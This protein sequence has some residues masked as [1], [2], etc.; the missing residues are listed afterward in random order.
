M[1]AIILLRWI[2]S[3]LFFDDAS[4]DCRRLSA[5][6]KPPVHEKSWSPPRNAATA[7]SASTF[8]LYLSGARHWLN[9]ATLSPIS[10][11][12]IQGFLISDVVSNQGLNSSSRPGWLPAQPIT[13]QEG[14]LQHGS[15][16]HGVP[17]RR[18]LPAPCPPG[19]LGEHK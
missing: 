16:N 13:D 18:L 15:C 14:R 3:Q 10:R 4:K 17:A 7:V 6:Q 9:A 11:K 19:G 8:Y 2:F 5:Y 1:C 12:S